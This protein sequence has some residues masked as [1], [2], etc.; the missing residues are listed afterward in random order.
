MTDQPI[1]FVD[2]TFKL[3]TDGSILF[4]QELKSHQLGVTNGDKFEV[5]V[6]PEV[7]I[8]FRKTLNS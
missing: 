2:Y 4:D 7:G 3:E 6:I 5:V 1:T 8:V